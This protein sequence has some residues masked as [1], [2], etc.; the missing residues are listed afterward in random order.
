MNVKWVSPNT[1]TGDAA[2]EERYLRRGYINEYFWKE[3]AKGNHI[4]FVAPR[5]VGKTSVM[6]DL[7]ADCGEEYVCIYQNIEGVKSRNEFYKRLY[8]LIL[9]CV[10]NSQKA[11]SFVTKWFKTYGISE[12]SKS[13]LKFVDKEIDYES[14]LRNL[15][16]ALK[17][18][19][20]HTVIFLD[21]F[22]EVINKLN[23]QG[24]Q[25]DAVD[26]L[27]TL[28][29]IRSDDDFRHFTIVFAGS[30][31]LQFVIKGID[32]PKLIN[33]LHPV[34]IGAL[35]NSE[36]LQLIHQLTQDVTIQIFPEIN[37]YLLKKTEHLLPYYI[38]LMLEEIDLVARESNQPLINQKMVDD[39]FNRVLHKNKNFDDWLVRLKEYQG[40]YGLCR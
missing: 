35:T 15:I 27:H 31:G 28:R 26:M 32:R 34:D 10:S 18:I 37:N 40:L 21:E 6:K 30:I 16:P 25:Q 39:A 36:A 5:R 12:I 19:K 8:E 2:T 38:Q 7:V 17:E 24:K 4:L 23:K 1:I 20:L 14:E 11:K 3:V 9:Q 29:E 22:A 33:D 13:G